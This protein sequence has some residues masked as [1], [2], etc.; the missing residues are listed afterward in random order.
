MSNDRKPAYESLADW[1]AALGVRARAAFALPILE[2]DAVANAEQHIHPDFKRWV[3][4][5]PMV[6]GNPASRYGEDAPGYMTKDGLG[7]LEIGAADD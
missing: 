1:L 6:T 4:G 5:D 2:E 3:H 7:S